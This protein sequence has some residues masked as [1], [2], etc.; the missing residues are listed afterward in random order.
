MAKVSASSTLR[1]WPERWNGTTSWKH[2]SVAVRE[3]KEVGSGVVPIV[4]TEEIKSAMD[5]EGVNARSPGLI[6][7]E[8]FKMGK[9]VHEEPSMKSCWVLIRKCVGLEVA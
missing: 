7:I 2:S 6:D 5:V 8:E 4:G 3:C 1:L 9:P